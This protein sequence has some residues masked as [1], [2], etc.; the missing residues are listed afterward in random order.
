MLI[1]STK[2]K[3]FFLLLSVFLLSLS[4]AF[5]QGNDNKIDL[6][7]LD[8]YFENARKEWNI[9]G[10]AVAIVKNNEVILAKGYGVRDIRYPD[11]VDKNTLFGIASNSKAF[12]AACIM[13]LVEDNKLI[14]DNPVT[15]YLPYFEMYDP[16]VSKEITV[17]DLLC[18]RSGL[19]TFSGDLIWYA[20]NYTRKEVIERIKYLKPTTSFRSKY[21]YSNL[22]FLTAGEI[23]SNISGLTWDEYVKTKIF[24]PLGMNSS[25][26]SIKDE[27]KIKNIATPHLTA[28]NTVIP[29]EFINWDNMA[30]A[31]GINSSVSDMSKWLITQ[32]NKGTYNDTIIFSKKSSETMWTPQMISR[33]SHL[34]S[35]IHFHA[36]GLGWD[37][38]DYHGR[39][40]VNHSGGL[41][42]MISHVALVPEENLGLVVL[43]NSTNY[44][45]SALMYEIIDKFIGVEEHDWSS[46][47]LQFQNNYNNYKEKQKKLDEENRVKNTKPSLKLIEYT[48]IYGGPMY[49]NAKISLID[50][51][52]EIDFLP[53]TIFSATL[54]HW[55]F[56]TFELIF[57]HYPSL[58]NGKV[59]FLLD[60]EG[61][62]VEFKVNVPNPDFD[63]TELEFKKIEE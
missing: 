22:M 41:D 9:P 35:T 3:S 10:M 5:S 26:T 61:K 24:Q 37:L 12:T 50:D 23:V 46:V 56:D 25:N 52:L 32:L 2:Q 11:K 34:D 14:L 17:R 20:S 31:G 42:G 7:S 53:T 6:K 54:K 57:K 40:I 60:E 39:L 44:L 49:G 58:P 38:F 33:T 59:Q 36:Y 28:N 27:K 47:F 19:G 18:H 43:T 29:L 62:V 13:K 63:F 16:Y 30:P 21:G 45:P 8:N 48:G 51:H 55:H 4:L 1:T 15:D